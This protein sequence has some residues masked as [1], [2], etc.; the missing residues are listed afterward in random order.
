MNRISPILVCILWGQVSNLKCHIDGCEWVCPITYLLITQDA[1]KQSWLNS[2]ETSCAI[3][4]TYTPSFVCI[5]W[6]GDKWLKLECTIIE[7][8]HALCW[9]NK[10]VIGLT[11]LSREQSEQERAVVV[12]RA[13]EWMKRASCCS[14]A[15]PSVKQTHRPAALNTSM[16]QRQRAERSRG[17]SRAGS[18][19]PTAQRL[20]SRNLLNTAK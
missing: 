2:L 14:S 15:P 18:Y 3:S 17:E 11:P 13:R 12:K 4:S 8:L 1:F 16:T 9:W 6:R 10:R 19:T 5:W 7:M 20:T